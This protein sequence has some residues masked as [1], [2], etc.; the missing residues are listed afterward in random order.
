MLG[1]KIRKLRKFHRLSQEDLAKKLMVSKGCISN[2]E[3]GNTVP[4]IEQL[5]KLA[6]FFNVQS[7]YLLDIQYESRL[8]S[9]SLTEMQI[10]AIQQLIDIIDEEMKS[11]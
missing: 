10:L 9:K 1:D 7:D 11:K 4:S 2:W 5:K 8:N 6:L 3:N